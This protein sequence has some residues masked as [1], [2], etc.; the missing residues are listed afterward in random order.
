M[1]KI[2]F[3]VVISFLCLSSLSAQT[4][5]KKINLSPSQKVSP[6]STVGPL[7][8]LAVMVEFQKDKDET[9]YGDGTFGSIYSQ[10]YGKKIL[11]PLPFDQNFFA[12]HLEFVK[13]LLQKGFR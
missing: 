1:R 13:K 10:N 12:S 3:S 4:F 11:D 2:L 8:I 9:T 6:A 7:K 5:V